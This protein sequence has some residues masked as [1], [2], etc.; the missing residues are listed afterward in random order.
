VNEP[1]AIVFYPESPG[2]TPAIQ[3]WQARNPDWRRSLD[4][5]I[6]C[7]VCGIA[8]R[9]IADFALLDHA[10]VQE[11]IRRYRDEYL[12]AACSDHH[13]PTEEYWAMETSRTR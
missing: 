12:R 6:I 1:V 13:L 9:A 10:D 7:P 11:E 3:E 2:I 4:A 8:V 5:V